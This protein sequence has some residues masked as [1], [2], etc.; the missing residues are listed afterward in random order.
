MLQLFIEVRKR[1]TFQTQKKK[2]VHHRKSTISDSRVV[3]TYHFRLFD[4]RRRRI[5][6]LYQRSPVVEDGTYHHPQGKHVAQYAAVG[7]NLILGSFIGRT[8]IDVIRATVY[9]SEFHFSTHPCSPGSVAPSW[10]FALTRAG[11]A[12]D[13]WSPAR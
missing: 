1:Y 5:S 4:V 10:T 12:P 8:E 2:S 11:R 7:V 3:D 9:S 13:P 6:G